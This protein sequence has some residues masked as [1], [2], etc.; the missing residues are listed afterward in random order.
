M[1]SVTQ[2]KVSDLIPPWTTPTWINHRCFKVT[3]VSL[4]GVMSWSSR[5][6]LMV[7]AV[8]YA[9]SNILSWMVR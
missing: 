5:W 6:P 8:L 9:A 7:P 3:L 4:L 1:Q 2:L